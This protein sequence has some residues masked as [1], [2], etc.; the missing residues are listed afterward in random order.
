LLAND[1]TR[2]VELADLDGDGDLDALVVYQETAAVWLNDGQAGFSKGQ[3]LSFEEQ[4]AL[5]LGDLDGD[6]HIDIF[7]GSVYHDVLVWF[8][9]GAGQFT[10]EGE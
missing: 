6:G 7:A 3:S 9:D 4:H 8:N 10:R 1:Y 5:A 2:S